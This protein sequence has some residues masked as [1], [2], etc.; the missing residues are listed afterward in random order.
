MGKK[1]ATTTGATVPFSFLK[2]SLVALDVGAANEK[3]AEVKNMDA[4]TASLQA[5]F[6]TLDSSLILALISDYPPSTIEAELPAIRDQLAILQACS[7]PDENEVNV[8][9][10]A[11]A[12]V[13]P[14]TSTSTSDLTDLMDRQSISVRDFADGPSPPPPSSWKEVSRREVSK[15]K[16]K[17]KGSSRASGASGASGTGSTSTKVSMISGLGSGSGSAS[18]KRSEGGMLP[19]PVASGSGSGSG[20]GRSQSAGGSTSPTSV[21]EETEEVGLED[22]MGLLRSLFPNLPKADVRDALHTAVSFQAAIDQLLSVELIENVKLSGAWPG[23]EDQALAEEEAFIDTPLKRTTSR[24]S[25]ETSIPMSRDSSGSSITSLSGKKAKPKHY[26]LIDTLQRIPT[27]SSHSS[28]RASTPAPLTRTYGLSGPA[29]NAWHTLASLASQLAKLLHPHPE[30]YFTSFLHSPEYP[31]QHTAVH[32]ALARLPAVPLP[33]DSACESILQ[34]LYGVSL[35]EGDAERKQ[36]DL[37]AAMRVCGEDIGAVM[38]LV[39]LLEEVSHWAAT[40]DVQDRYGGSEDEYEI[41]SGTFET[42]PNPSAPSA[43]R[44]GFG[45]KAPELPERFTRKAKKKPVELLGPKVIPGAQPAA[46]SAAFPTAYDDF[47]APSPRSAPST[48]PSNKGQRHVKNWHTVA[49]DRPAPRESNRASGPSYAYS[50]SAAELSVQQCLANAELE[51]HKRTTAIRAA[52]LHFG[53]GHLPGGKAVNRT[54]ASHYA[55]QAR[56]AGNMERE[57]HLKAARM[58]IN[59]QLTNSGHVVDLHSLTTAE[60]VTVAKEAVATWY[61]KQKRAWGTGLGREGV[62][63]PGKPMEIITGVGNHSVGGR[64]VLGPA[65]AKALEKDGWRVERGGDS[66]GYLR[67]KGRN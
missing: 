66:S 57:W 28:S 9:F 60:A 41:P 2:Q 17:G 45:S 6:D 37:K 42:L 29:P 24:A 52:G 10:G 64:G 35:T 1:R 48:R 43:L 65:V 33:A 39:E 25:F 58:V 12:D 15:K 49:H 44:V 14:S 13:D 55:T 8:D 31:S 67:V 5:E 54:V 3:E 27:P 61:E 34:D 38:D 7:V 30:S 16:G 50:T 40:E 47:G 19:S 11:A 26:A 51:R 23:E 20:S 46:S 63:V 56:D 62:F 22:E 18:A 36:H 59:N 21:P 32:A 4:I 53:G